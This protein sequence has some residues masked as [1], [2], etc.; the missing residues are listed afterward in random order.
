MKIWK[1][2]ICLCLLY[3]CANSSGSTNIN[4]DLNKTTYDAFFDHYF[5]LGESV[6]DGDVESV[7]KDS[8]DLLY[9]SS[10]FRKHAYID[11]IFNTCLALIEIKN[12]DECYSHYSDLSSYFNHL[13][14][15]SPYGKDLNLYRCQDGLNF[16]QDQNHQKPPYPIGI[17]NS[18]EIY[19]AE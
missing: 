11:S 18:F 15:N 3:S 2:F 13:H 16:I 14:N 9:I 19:T 4:Y 5:Q 6:S 12:V 8:D 10:A 1:Q 7:I 17:C